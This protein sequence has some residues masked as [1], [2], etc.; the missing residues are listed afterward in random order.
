VVAHQCP[1][2]E[3]T[4][5]G[6]NGVA[7]SVDEPFPNSVIDKETTSVD[8]PDNHGMQGTRCVQTGVSRHEPSVRSPQDCVNTSHT[9]KQ[10]ACNTIMVILRVMAHDTMC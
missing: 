7:E 3:G 5:R 9:G 1:G 6:G 8:S 10:R 4:A 2:V